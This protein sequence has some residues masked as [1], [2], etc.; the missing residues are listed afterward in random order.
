[1]I[2]GRLPNGYDEHVSDGGKSLSLGESQLIS[3][4]RALA[5]DPA[6]FILDEA[7]ANVDTETESMIQHALS[8]VQQ[9]RTTLIIAH[10]LS[11]IRHADNIYVLESDKI[12]ETGKHEQLLKKRGIY[13][14]MYQMQLGLR[15]QVS[16]KVG[17][18]CINNR[19][20]LNVMGRL[21]IFQLIIKMRKQMNITTLMILLMRICMKN[22]MKMNCWN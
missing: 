17:S 7:T 11:T 6:I 21:K 10:R 19:T 1:M 15:K 9:N 3:L 2:C 22:L 13:Y 8:V 5:Y 14:E 16:Q 4:A 18:L 12:V 20:I